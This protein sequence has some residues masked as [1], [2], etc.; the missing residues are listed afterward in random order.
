MVRSVFVWVIAWLLV[1]AWPVSVCA[2]AQPLASDVADLRL[3]RAD[4]GLYLSAT[5]QFALPELAEDALYK[6]IPMFFVAE[7]QVLR[8]RWYWSDRQV[9]T[10]TRH[11]RLSY[12][13]L[14]RR[15][16]LST[17]TSPISNTGLGVVLGQNFDDLRDAVS[18][19]QRISRWKIANADEIDADAVHKVN[20]RFRLDMSQLPRPLQIGAVGSA[21]WSLA[22]TRNQWLMPEAAR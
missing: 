17:S 1:L 20:F 18:A 5:L 22:V 4:D 7:A 16:R 2:Q 11:L 10:A 6:G 3:E 19:M 9:A 15:W 21:G 8:E 12:Q 13:P 14:T